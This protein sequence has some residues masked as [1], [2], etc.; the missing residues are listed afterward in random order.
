MAETKRPDK[1]NYYLNIAEQVLERSTCLRRNYGAVIVKNDEIISTGYNGAPRGWENCTDKGECIREKMGCKSGER[2]ELC[3]AVHADMNAIISAKRSD[4][5]GATFYLVGK[6]ADGKLLP[7]TCPCEVCKRLIINAGI[8]TIII[9]RDK[10]KYEIID[11]ASQY[12]EHN[13]KFMYTGK[14]NAK[15]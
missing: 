15:A 7:D 1:H 6:G 11:V 4:M 2:T 8:A 10:T 3:R 5:I 14:Y 12:T 13:E 9:R